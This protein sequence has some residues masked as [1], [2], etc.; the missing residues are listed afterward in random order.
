MSIDDVGTTT[1]KLDK[2][3]RLS[4]GPE[5]K[6]A[7]VLVT[8]RSDGSLVVEPALAMPKR[9]LWVHRGEAGKSMARALDQA[10]SGQFVDGPDVEAD[11]AEFEDD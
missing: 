1:E 9:E 3:G 10:R 2:Q 5:Y 8:H 6:Y 7:L 11:L 4:L